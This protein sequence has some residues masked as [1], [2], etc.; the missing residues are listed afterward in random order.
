MPYIGE[1]RSYKSVGEEEEIL[2]SFS[3]EIKAQDTDDEIALQFVKYNIIN[4]FLAHQV[5]RI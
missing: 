3:E 5:H 2:V 4:L 1:G